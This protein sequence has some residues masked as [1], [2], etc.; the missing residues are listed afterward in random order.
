MANSSGQAVD[1]VVRGGEG[2]VFFTIPE[3][4]T[5][6]RWTARAAVFIRLRMA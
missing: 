1:Q 2:L 6:A 5:L 4:V 3:V